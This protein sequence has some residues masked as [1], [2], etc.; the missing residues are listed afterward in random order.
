MES[1]GINTKRNLK[2]EK[3][4]KRNIFISNKNQIEKPL[5]GEQPKNNITNSEWTKEEEEILFSLGNKK[6]KKKWILI[7]NK[8][9]CKKSPSQCFY[10]Y[11]AHSPNIRHNQWTSEEDSQIKELYAKYGKK[12]EKISKLMG[13][14]TG[15]QIRDRFINRLDKGVFRRKFTAEEDKKLFELY[16][17]HG[18]SWSKIAEEMKD[19]SG[20]MIKNRF[21][22][23]IKKKFLNSSS[24]KEEGINNNFN[25]NFQKEVREEENLKV[26]IYFLF[27]F[28]LKNFTFFKMFSLLNRLIIKG[29]IE[30]RIKMFPPHRKI[31][32]KTQ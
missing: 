7:S 16:L 12:W 18:H 30:K 14:R 27:K 26:K 2:E 19:R 4:K 1:N 21:Y 3:T 8:L 9:N 31:L 13:N 15:K 10:H 32:R 17:K 24:F 28:H 22:S 6:N 20:D 5:E 29:K 23:F 11:K 25:F